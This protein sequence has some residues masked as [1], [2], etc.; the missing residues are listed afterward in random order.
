M[1]SLLSFSI[2]LICCLPAYLLIICRCSSVLS[3][4]QGSSVLLKEMSSN[5]SKCLS[6]FSSSLSNCGLFLYCSSFALNSI[7]SLSLLLASVFL[8]HG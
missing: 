1:A 4:L 8:L 2:S 7:A 6:S 5:S 3:L